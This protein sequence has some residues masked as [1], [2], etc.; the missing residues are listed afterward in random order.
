MWFADI[1]PLCSRQP[2]DNR[3]VKMFISSTDSS[4]YLGNYAVFRLE[5]IPVYG[6]I[7]RLDCLMRQVQSGTK[8]KHT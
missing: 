7:S 6:G 8:I 2:L 4:T 1:S 5:L 3:L